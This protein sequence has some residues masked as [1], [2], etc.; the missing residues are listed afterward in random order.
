M[1][2]HL[3]TEILEQVEFLPENLQ[4][5]VLA[6]ARSLRKT[7]SRGI[8]GKDLARFAGRISENDLKAMR[9]AIET[10]CEHIDPN[11]W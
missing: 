5:K 7:H 8:P 1:T 9:H 6:F 3:T 11:E 4:F 10:D 2:T